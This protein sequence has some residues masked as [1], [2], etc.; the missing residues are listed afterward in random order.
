M[1]PMN[2]F[3]YEQMNYSTYNELVGVLQLSTLKLAIL[4]CY[5]NG[6]VQSVVCAGLD[7]SRGTMNHRKASIVKSITI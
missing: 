4:N 6:I 7:I 1:N 3:E 2:R 5:M